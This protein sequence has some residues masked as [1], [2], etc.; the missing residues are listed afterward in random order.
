MNMGRSEYYKLK[1]K[2][3]DLQLIIKRIKPIVISKG[4]FS[5]SYPYGSFGIEPDDVKF[6][7]DMYKKYM[8]K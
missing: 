4:D 6:F 3:R 8:G 7:E 2:E 1:E 5:V